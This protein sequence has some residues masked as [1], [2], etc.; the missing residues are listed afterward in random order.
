MTREFQELA[1]IVNHPE[2][3]LF[4]TYMDKKRMAC[5]DRLEICSQDGLGKI[6]GELLVIK[7]I[8]T[9]RKTVNSI[10]SSR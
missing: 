8:L 6:Q 5:H 10:M 7:D 3:D 2:W 4:M 1:S 9:L